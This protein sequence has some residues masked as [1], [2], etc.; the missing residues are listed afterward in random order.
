[1][2][3]KKRNNGGV[4]TLGAILLLLG[5][6]IQCSDSRSMSLLGKDDVSAPGSP[7][8]VIRR[9]ED[10]SVTVLGQISNYHASNDFDAGNDHA[11]SGTEHSK[12]TSVGEF[13][14]LYEP[15][16]ISEVLKILLF[17]AGGILLL[18][19]LVKLR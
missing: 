8:T 15:V 16:S 11:F 5:L 4:G 3:L 6:I 7:T 19:S 18:T 13:L 9:G 1:M 10:G 12:T 17:A 14:G 2:P